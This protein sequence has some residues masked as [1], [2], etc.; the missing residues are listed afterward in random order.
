MKS[1]YEN[2]LNTLEQYHKT[3]W[4]AFSRDSS[5]EEN[6]FAFVTQAKNG[7]CIVGC[8][9]NGKDNYLNSTYN[10]AREAEKLMSEYAVMPENAFL[11][12]FGLANGSFART[13]LR[14][15]G[16][17]VAIYVYEPSKEVFS[18]VM[19]NIDITELLADKRFHIV[20]EPYNA[21]DFAEFL[22]DYISEANE[23]TNRYMAIPVYQK[24]F[25]ESYDHYRQ[26]IRDKYE[27]YRIQTNTLIKVGKEIG[28]ASVR[29]MRFLPDC[30]S[31]AEYKNYFPQDIPAIIVAAGPSLKKNVNLLKE[32]K[33][34]A[35]TIV[36]DS[37]I[38]TVMAHG[39]VPD[40]AITVDTNKE[41]KN[42]TA[43]GLSDV[44]LLADATANTK[45]LDMVKSKNLVFYSSDSATWQ[46]MF[47]EEGSSITEVFA[48]GSVAL[49][50][51]ALAK[52][53]GFKRIIMIGQDL[54][55]TG[56]KQYADGENLN[57]NTSFNSPTLYVK[58]IYG[59]DVLTKK[60][61]YTFIRSIEDLAYRNPDI[62]FIDA[63]EGGAFKKHT[64]IMT[65][66]EAIDTYCTVGY[67]VTGR[68]EAVPRLFEE[69]GKKK[70][71][72]NLSLMR[73]H[74]QTL[75]DKMAVG[76]QDCTLAAH[77]L[78][79]GKFDKE[80]LKKINER[81]RELDA[82]YADMEEHI[83]V[84]KISAQANYDFGKEVYQT[85]KDDIQESIRLYKNS[86]KL[87]QGIADS[88]DCIIDE[89]SKVESE[90]TNE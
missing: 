73:E 56:N 69:E 60:D 42:F 8:H 17:G 67:D 62:D 90:I 41:L 13:Y 72:D 46:R 18:A 40:F 86:A 80:V 81:N 65:L 74:V 15:N 20:V 79:T 25:P 76:A 87:Y 55:M 3:L 2:N 66:Q 21:D 82:Y 31:G 28:L 24:V 63:T 33:G 23:F 19:H 29:N 45:A 89:I 71:L 9:T 77:M 11:C 5:L 83:L 61:Y 47:R 52:E 44:F 59:N 68:I 35:V 49:D 1:I 6:E 27:Y 34:K 84:K 54:A 26:V 78:E 30:R 38:N 58:D 37:A 48:G 39:I 85:L 88:T 32:V 57:Q 43:E 7:E 64:R 53:W 50:A 75:T 22:L 10:P 12:M 70:V 4:E 36:V 14:E 51:M 16:E